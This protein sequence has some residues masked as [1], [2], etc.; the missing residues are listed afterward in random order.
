VVSEDSRRIPQQDRS[1]RRYDQI[2]D[3]A[4][5]LFSEKGFERTTTNEIASRAGI[6]IGSLYQYFR[7]KEAIVVA[8]M[9]RYV[10]AVRGVTDE[11]MARDVQA[12]SVAEA[13]DQLLDPYVRFHTENAAFSRL[14]LGAD[15]SDQ[16][17]EAIGRMS[18]EALA[19]I[20]TLVRARI[21]G[22]R[23]DRARL[24]SMVTQGIVKSLL[25]L[26]M[27]SDDSRFREQAAAEVKHML[28]DYFESLI[29]EHAPKQR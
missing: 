16:L 21:R 13:I 2:L 23:K 11:F 29:R 18:E 8:L 28:V 26:L 17:D 5:N 1:R 4:T 20:N 6:S 7:N 10:E 22:I 15:L 9:D 3:V 25:S 19:R 12:L 14:W 27:Q 24:V